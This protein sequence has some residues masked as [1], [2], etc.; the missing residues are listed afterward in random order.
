MRRARQA[1]RVLDLPS[2]SLAY[3]L[4]AYCGEAADKQLQLADWRV[5]NLTKIIGVNSTNVHQN[6]DAY[7]L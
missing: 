4:D 2:F 3:L 6:Y 1:A 7:R 5:I